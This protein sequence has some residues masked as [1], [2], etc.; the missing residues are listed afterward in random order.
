VSDTPGWLRLSQTPA[1][2][3]QSVIFAGTPVI[4]TLLSGAQGL[5]VASGTAG[6]TVTIQGQSSGVYFALNT[7][8]PFVVP[9]GGDEPYQITVTATTEV[10]AVYYPP[11]PPPSSVAIGSLPNV[12]IGS[13]PAITIAAGQFVGLAA[14][15]LAVTGLLFAG[16]TFTN[17][18]ANTGDVIIAAQAGKVITIYSLVWNIAASAA[19]VGFYNAEMRETVTA[20]KIDS[21][22]FR[23]A[24]AVG[25]TGSPAHPWHPPGAKLTVSNGLTVVTGALNAGGADISGTVAYTIA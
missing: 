7:P 9:L 19:T 24:T 21:I 22:S 2:V 23:L 6:A 8:A 3:F 14:G 4:L 15:S 5:L 10:W 20:N 12:T 18:A 13:M 1:P 16:F 25:N 11:I 17:I